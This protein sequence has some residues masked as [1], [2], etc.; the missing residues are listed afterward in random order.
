MAWQCYSE[1]CEEVTSQLKTEQQARKEWIIFLFAVFSACVYHTRKVV[2]I[3]NTYAL[4]LQKDCFNV[5]SM[6]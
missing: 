5:I 3:E 1:Q 2:S 4:M 6:L